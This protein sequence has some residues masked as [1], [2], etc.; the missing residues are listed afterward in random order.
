ML[1]TV[2]ARSWRALEVGLAPCSAISSS[3]GLAVTHPSNAAVL[4]VIVAILAAM[5]VSLGAI[6]VARAA[7]Q[8]WPI[9][10][11]WAAGTFAIVVPLMFQIFDKL[12][13]G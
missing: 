9:S 7:T 1:D 6:F 4:L 2:R 10:I 12:G 13:L 8:T 11:V 3:G 5:L